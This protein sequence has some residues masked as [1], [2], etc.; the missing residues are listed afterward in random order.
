MNE[1]TRLVNGYKS[2]KEW[3]SFLSTA[4]GERNT[5]TVKYVHLFD[6][7]LNFVSELDLVFSD[8]HSLLES[9][10]VN[11]PFSKIERAL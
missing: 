4:K 11:H 3:L 5:D 7:V 8:E 6:K 1:N 9:M 10:F 2:L